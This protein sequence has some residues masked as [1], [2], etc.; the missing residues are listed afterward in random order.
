M[1]KKQMQG[2]KFYGRK[3]MIIDLKEL[4]LTQQSFLPKSFGYTCS[5]P[6]IVLEIKVLADKLKIIFFLPWKNNLMDIVQNETLV[7]KNITLLVNSKPN[8]HKHRAK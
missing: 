6:G 1:K 4:S 3:T 5:S 7:S 2:N 8:D